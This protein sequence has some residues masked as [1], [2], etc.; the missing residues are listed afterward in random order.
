M[1]VNDETKVN[2]NGL[3]K[4][5]VINETKTH[6][7]TDVDLK[8]LNIE[9]QV[10]KHKLTFLVDS[11]AVLETFELGKDTPIN[12]NTCQDDGCQQTKDYSKLPNLSE[13][14]FS[15]ENKGKLRELIY[16]YRDTFAYSMQELGRCSLVQHTI[17]TGTSQPIK[18]KRKLKA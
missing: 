9:G 14:A 6:I 17:D 8:T 15:E 7:E 2:K 1:A 12:E 16:K 10:G 5:N 4:L 18:P 11:G 3:P 13:C